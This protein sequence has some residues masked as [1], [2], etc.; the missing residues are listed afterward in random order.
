MWNH[1]PQKRPL[2]CF[3]LPK[4]FSLLLYV[5]IA[6]LNI[7]TLYFILQSFP[8]CTSTRCRFGAKCELQEDGSESCVC[9]RSC[10][11]GYVPVCGN[12]QKTYLNR[13]A[14]DLDTCV[15]NG[16]VSLAHEGKCCTNS[17]LLFVCLLPFCFE[18]H[19]QMLNTINSFTSKL[20][21]K[22][23]VISPH[24]FMLLTT[25]LITFTRWNFLDPYISQC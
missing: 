13:C 21:F 22:V 24:A 14:L 9:E 11:L 16:T 1:S 12:N 25:I 3:K 8:A 10:H 18:L 5:P 17:H 4:D 20:N 7:F 23:N 2:V 19:V 15:T 6:I